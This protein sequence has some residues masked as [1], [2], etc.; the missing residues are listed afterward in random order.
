MKQHRF[1]FLVTLALCLAGCGGANQDDVLTW[2]SRG[3]IAGRFAAPRAIGANGGFVYVIDRTGR[4]QKFTEQGEFVLEWLLEN[5]DKGTPTGLE[6]DQN[7]DLWIPDTHQNRILKYSSEGEKLFTFGGYGLEPGSFVYP[8]DIAVAK[9]GNLYISEYGRNGRVQVFSPEGE[10]LF[11]WGSFGSGPE[12]F[13]RPMAILLGRDD[14][15]Y[16]AD[17]VNHRIKVYDLQGNLLRIMGR[18]GS[19]PGEFLFPYDLAMGDDGNLIVCEWGNHRVQNITP[20][21]K[22]IRIWGGLGA[23]PGQLAE[24]W[25]VTENAGRVFVADTKNHRIQVFSF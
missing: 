20:D 3:R 6:F 18:E 11:S 13:N 15:L 1:V 16:I 9:N 21:G 2:G 25:G 4:V 22:P 8:T 19:E 10:F 23:S 12:Q 5:P 14:N 7:G 24:P 17:S